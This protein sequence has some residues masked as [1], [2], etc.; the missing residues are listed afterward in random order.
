[1]RY[2]L[3][4]LLLSCS[5]PEEKQFSG[6][7]RLMTR[8]AA[9]QR[10]VGF[11]EW[12]GGGLDLR[13]RRRLQ[14]VLV[15][16]HGLREAAGFRGPAGSGE[17]V[18]TPGCLR[19]PGRAGLF[20]L[21]CYQGGEVFRRAWASGCGIPVEQVRGCGSETESAL[22]TCLLLHLLEDGPASLECWF[23]EWV[24]CNEDLEP[25]FPA[26]RAAYA[27]SGGDPLA[28]LAGLQGNDALRPFAGFLAAV[29]RH[30]DYL[31]GLA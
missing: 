5:G 1:M 7:R 21:G 19:L 6:V 10:R 23:A 3:E 22:S 18:L 2:G 25:L 16:G 8:L 31:T 26:I 15:S 17:P 14:R 20:L 29:G 24:R 12:R 30:P 9:E 27:A 4:C 13:R 11:L 28:V